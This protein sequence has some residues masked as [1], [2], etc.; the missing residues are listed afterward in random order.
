MRQKILRWYGELQVIERQAR[1]ATTPEDQERIE[2]HLQQ[3]ERGVS[4]LSVALGAMESLY[5]LRRN[6]QLAAQRLSH[7]RETAG[8]ATPAP[9]MSLWG[10][11]SELSAS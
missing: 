8:P 6:V 5:E 7:G 9:R 2:R 4:E 11:E 1:T 3:V 10:Q